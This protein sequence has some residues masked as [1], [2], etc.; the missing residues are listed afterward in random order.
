MRV[1]RLGWAGLELE[2]GGTRLVIDYVRDLSPVFTGWKPG[3]GLATPSGTVAAALVTHLHRDH[4]D[5]AA[6]ADVLAPGAP[7]LRPAP[8]HGDDVDNVMTLLV[9]RELALRRLA[10]EVVDAWSTRDLGPFRV[11]AVPAVDGLG[12]PQLN[13]VVQADG[14]R[15]LHGGDTLFHGYWWLIARR[16]SP[17]DAVFLPANG[18]VVDVPHLRPPSP[19]PAAMD[20]RQAGAAAELLG[21]RYAVPMHYEAEQPDKTAGYVEVSDPEKEFR[22]HA[23]RRAHVLAVGEW[24]DLAT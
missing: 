3:E 1:R 8:G 13:W 17:F 16:F 23:G 18:A 21:A 12:D 24:L 2:A 14:Q 10:T 15:V 5:V 6:L 19:L 9:E 22:T 11:T 4:T 7:V 20:P